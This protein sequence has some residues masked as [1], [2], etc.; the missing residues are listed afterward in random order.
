MTT[1]RPRGFTL[2]E[3]IMVIVILAIAS[4]TVATMVANVNAHQGDNT[5][6]QVGTQLLQE[7][8][9]NIVAQHRR[10]ENFFST[11][12]GASSSNCYSLT[13]LTPSGFSLP[14]VAV[15]AYTGPGCPGTAECK[16][17]TVTL[18]KGG[19]TLQTLNV[20]LVRYN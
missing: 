12:M 11:T 10:D 5:D 19:A 9:E 8:G 14:T 7:C 13:T 20:M 15:A 1:R 18:A 16:V 2:L 17:A 4:I 3:M 6:L